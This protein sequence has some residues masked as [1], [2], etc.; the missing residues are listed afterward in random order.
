MISTHKNIF[1]KK[2][3]ESLKEKERFEE[4][5]KSGEIE[6]TEVEVMEK[7]ERLERVSRR[8]ETWLTNTLRKDIIIDIVN[9][10]EA[11]IAPSMMEKAVGGGCDQG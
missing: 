6:P 5:E 1:E 2:G 7:E 9:G 4:E 11:A 10:M 8:K 3:N